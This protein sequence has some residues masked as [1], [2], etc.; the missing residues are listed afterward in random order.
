MTP[1]TTDVRYTTAGPLRGPCGHKHKNLESA[2]ECLA[3]DEAVC[4]VRGGHTDRKIFVLERGSR[5]ELN[6]PELEFVRRYLPR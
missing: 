2:A 3:N 1:P 4:A 5:R 6:A